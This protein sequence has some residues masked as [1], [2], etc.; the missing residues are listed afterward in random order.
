MAIEAGGPAQDAPVASAHNVLGLDCEG[1]AEG[2]LCNGA[3]YTDITFDTPYVRPPHVLVAVENV[4][5]QGGCVG[6]A[7]DQV[8]A[9]PANVTER[10]FRLYVHGSPMQS[11]GASEGWSSRATAGYLVVPQG[12]QRASAHGLSPALCTGELTGGLCGGGFYDDQRFA[13]PLL[14]APHVITSGEV[15]SSQGGCVGGAMDK[16]SVYPT[17]IDAAGFRLFARGSPVSGSCGA[18]DGH[19]TRARAGFFAIQ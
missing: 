14:S 5:N 1:V 12:P 17:A 11:C 19:G 4:S 9:R 2:G 10:G 6:G 15:I 7:T 8:V 3:F 13:A 18:F 16:L